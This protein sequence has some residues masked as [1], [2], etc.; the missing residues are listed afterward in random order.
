M[1]TRQHIPLGYA[2]QPNGILFVVGGVDHALEL[3]ELPS[4]ADTRVLRC[5]GVPAAAPF[6][7]KMQFAPNKPSQRPVCGQA[8]GD[9]VAAAF[10]DRPE[11]KVSS[12]PG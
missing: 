9:Q 5:S 2:D 7:R 4:A 10:D 3:A 1:F 6:A 12:R 11:N 8:S